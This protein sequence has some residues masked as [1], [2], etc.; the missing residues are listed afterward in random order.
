MEWWEDMSDDERDAVVASANTGS[1]D[2]W[3]YMADPNCV[4]DDGEPCE[5]CRGG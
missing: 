4:C 3:S 5:L 2:D 1:S